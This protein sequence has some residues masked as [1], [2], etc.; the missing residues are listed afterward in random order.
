MTLSML[1]ATPQLAGSVFERGVL[2]LLEEQGGAL[3]LLLNRPAGVSIGDLLPD[4]GQAARSLPAYQGGPVE[5]SAGWCLYASPTGEAAETELA[6]QLWLSRDREV[7]GR[8]LAGEQP[9]YL[10]LGYAGWAPGQLER[11]EREG[12][13]L[14][15]EVSSE[16]LGALLWGTPDERKWLAA[17]E[18]LGTLPGNVV[19]GAQA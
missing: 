5:R 14:W 10:L 6:P 13:W 15:G 19:G 11:E 3:G 8:L 7:L 9:F 17:S 12:S 4:A 16:D 18:L 2:L 1:V